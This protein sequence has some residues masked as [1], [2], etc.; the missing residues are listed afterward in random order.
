MGQRRRLTSE[1]KRQA[2][3]LL[4][5]NQQ[6]TA[7]IARKLGVLRNRIRNGRR[8]GPRLSRHSQAPV[9]KPIPQP[10]RLSSSESGLR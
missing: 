3:L 2:L 8:K 9:G 7:K 6:P 10:N 5:A 4:N 1:F